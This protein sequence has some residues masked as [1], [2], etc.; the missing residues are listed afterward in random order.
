MQPASV[1]NSPVA[2]EPGIQPDVV[3]PPEP[4][5]QAETIAQ[6]G[7]ISQQEPDTTKQDL[8]AE[9]ESTNPVQEN[10]VSQSIH[11]IETWPPANAAAS[12]PTDSSGPTEPHSPVETPK[13]TVE[14]FTS[15]FHSIMESAG[16]AS[17]LLEISN[18]KRDF[19][20]HLRIGE[21][22]LEHGLYAD[23]IRS[24]NRSIELLNESGNQDDDE[25]RIYWCLV[26]A[27]PDN[28]EKGIE[29]LGKLFEKF[30]DQKYI[31]THPV[32]VE[33]MVMALWELY[34]DKW[35][36]P[37]EAMK[38]CHELLVGGADKSWLMDRA[39]EV[40]D[41][42][43]DPAFLHDISG[44]PTGGGPS[45]LTTLFQNRASDES[46]HDTLASILKTELGLLMKVYIDAIQAAES[47]AFVRSHL[48][49]Y[50]A[51]ALVYQ[52]CV[53]EACIIWE[54]NVHDE[55]I[56]IGQ[57]SHGASLHMCL[58]SLQ[59]LLSEYSQSTRNKTVQGQEIGLSNKLKTFGRWI[60]DAF[61]DSD[62]PVTVLLGRAYFVAGEEQLAKECMRAYVN[63]ALELL[64]DETTDNDWQGFYML[65]QATAAIDE[66]ERALAAWQLVNPSTE[67]GWEC[68]G[69]C[70]RFDRKHMD[71][72]ACKDCI[73]VQFE[74]SCFEKLRSGTLDVRV[75]GNTHRFVKLPKLDTK[76]LKETEKGL[77]HEQTIQDWLHD[78]KHLF[79][80]KSSDGEVLVRPE[81]P[82]LQEFKTLVRVLKSRTRG[83]MKHAIG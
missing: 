58:L 39:W 19:K 24:C 9:P 49:Y 46:F 20:W 77:V 63:T 78:I 1:E 10:T 34:N 53:E 11:V 7:S 4:T 47:D 61:G 31:K 44:T 74:Q 69:R 17:S 65:T 38:A 79:G 67:S 23:A 45:P 43:R 2:G 60:N 73:D 21:T 71:L 5:T 62:H 25:W 3:T 83:G 72:Y 32:E 29:S 22:V 41:A 57:D 12:H 13:Q 75:C 70:G 48:R 68:N 37:S 28:I 76:A 59:R 55:A 16:Y 36:R 26:R 56:T 33:N 42:K 64:S 81:R 18:D 8:S 52:N 66:D 80:I 51:I 30:K 14:T 50:Y 40:I 35:E 82:L 15:I 54:K 6:P 27:S